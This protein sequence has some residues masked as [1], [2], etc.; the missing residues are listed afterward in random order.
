MIK[1]TNKQAAACLIII[2][3]KN[4]RAGRPGT[5]GRPQ[6][7]SLPESL[8]RPSGLIFLIERAPEKGQLP[9]GPSNCQDSQDSQ[10]NQDNQDNQVKQDNQD[11]QNH[12][13][14][15]P[16]RQSGP[17]PSPQRDCQTA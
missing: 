6:S 16:D 12:I 15:L 17:A 4:I 5:A 9:A 3:P 13:V 8:N 2:S 7:E 11:K 14:R 1:D 10:D